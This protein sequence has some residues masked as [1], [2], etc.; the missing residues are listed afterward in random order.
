MVAN[1]PRVFFAAER[2]L[3]ARIRTAI[4]LIG[5]GF[6]VA[7]FSLFL[8]LIDQR[9]GIATSHHV[10]P[11]IGMGMALFGAIAAATSSWQH[12]RFCRAL[13][14]SDFPIGYRAGPALVVGFGVSIAGAVLLRCS[15]LLI[16]SI[17]CRR[18]GSHSTGQSD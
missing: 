14:E 7:R 11:W 1:D 3:L 8:Q 15:P 12:V 5:L 16:G 4:G 13:G 9:G 18:S 17:S 10:S 6:V 2:T